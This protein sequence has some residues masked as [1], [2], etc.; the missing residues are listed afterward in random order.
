MQNL[1]KLEKSRGIVAFA[2]NTQTTDYVAIAQ[3][4]LELASR[5]LGLPY[6]I[7]T[8][9]VAYENSRYDIDTKQFVTW[10]NAGRYQAYELSPY[11]ETLVIDV[12]YLVFD[13]QLASMFDTVTDYT[14]MRHAQGL[15]QQSATQMG[16]NS[17][18]YVWA[19]A[20]IF[21]KTPRAQ[22]F[23]DL[24]GRIQS[25]YSYYREL[26]NIQERNYRNDYAFGIADIILNGYQVGIG[27]LP[28]PMLNIDQP[29]KSITLHN[30][31]FFVIRDE[32]QA[33]VV[34][35]M[36]IHILSK[37]YLLSDQFQDFLNSV[38][39]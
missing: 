6:T 2:N 33:Y 28:G 35:R 23:F 34:P 30:D 1:K 38:T 7:I 4:T 15:T 20:F 36:N 21:K 5:T 31:H 9:P 24:V 10:N 32:A 11:D 19:T 39:A 29:I 3:R 25:N 18:P 22:M 14:I 26:F 8:N 12:D 37:A 16:P 27:S 17:L 13:C